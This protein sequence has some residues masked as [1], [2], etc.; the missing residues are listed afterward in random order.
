MTL[1]TASDRPRA[2]RDVARTRDN[3]G[4]TEMGLADRDYMK[5]ARPTTA[6]VTRLER[7]IIG[8]AERD[9]IPSWFRPAQRRNPVGRA[10]RIAAWSSLGLGA[11]TAAWALGCAVIGAEYTNHGKTFEPPSGAQET[12]HGRR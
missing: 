4:E 12:P 9:D 6:R 3:N 5:P 10:L 7:P 1:I 8:R 2:L 11:F